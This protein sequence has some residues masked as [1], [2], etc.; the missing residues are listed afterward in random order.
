MSWPGRSDKKEPSAEETSKWLLSHFRIS[1]EAQKPSEG[2]VK[3][4][5][6]LCLWYL[7]NK[8]SMAAYN[9]CEE[10]ARPLVGRF[11]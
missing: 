7:P 11:D 4:L 3:T 8:R 9:R 6:Q 2:V 1:E 5:Q 10:L